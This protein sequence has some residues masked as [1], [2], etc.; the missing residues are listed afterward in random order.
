MSLKKEL[1]TFG[2]VLKLL[3]GINIHP[4]YLLIPI[5]LGI[6]AAGFEGASISLLIPMLNGF[7]EQ[8]FSFLKETPYI[9]NVI[10][11]LPEHILD[12]DRNL[13]A[14]LM[15]VFVSAVLLKNI[16]KYLSTIAMSYFANRSMHHLRKVVFGRYL[17]F[18]KLYFDRSNVGHHA[19]VLSIFTEYALSP[20][21]NITK[22]MNALFSLIVY[23]IVMSMISWQLTFFALPL[24]AV[25]HVAVKT[26]IDHVRILSKKI[27]DQ[28]SELGKK[29]IEIL[30]TIPLVKSYSTATLEKNKY[31]DISNEK[32]RLDFKVRVI[33]ELMLPLQEVITLLMASGLFIVM[34]WLLVKEGNV[35]A[36]PFIVYFY[37]VLNAAAKFGTVTGFRSTLAKASGPLE[38][39]T[40]VFG[41]K[42]KFFVE[43][44]N[45]EFAGLQQTID[46]KNVS[47]NYGDGRSVLND[48]SL[49]IHKGEM[50]AIVGPTGGGKSTLINLIMRYYDCEPNSVFIDGVDIRDFG[51]T[52]LL[53]HIALVS[54]DTLLLHDTLAN[55]ITYGLSDV[56]EKELQEAIKRARLTELVKKMPQGLKT[57]IGDRGVKL[58]GGEKQ[59]VAIARALLKKAEILILDEATSSLDSRTEKLIQEAI[60]DAIKGRTAIV[61]AHR[62]ST[63]QH[64]DSIAVIE[65]GKSTEV[66]TLDELI[67]KKGTFSKLWEEQKFD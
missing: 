27:A 11:R 28:G 52:T 6:V 49:T 55:N 12:S 63:I 51:L 46:F 39:I 60:D 20:V 64:A 58:S 65:D 44:G 32:A 45:K 22:Y 57:L 26:L 4:A 56:S 25:L 15:C 50:T 38:E 24:F 53:N 47:F 14:V 16:F 66:G 42:E 30:S 36:P 61:I 41:D 40:R 34:L 54:Q 7:L 1:S 8:D 19:T 29:S 43:G 67:A 13:F 3:K 10:I 62:L 33:A 18:G 23:L 5:G 37:L 48:V 21:I 2:D 17:S 31:A 59:R 9:G 35:E